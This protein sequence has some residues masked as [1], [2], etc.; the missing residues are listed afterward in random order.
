M[1][2]FNTTFFEQSDKDI[3]DHVNDWSSVT[4]ICIMKDNTIQRFSGF[5]DE[6][7]DGEIFPHCDCMTS[8]DYNTDDIKYWGIIDNEIFD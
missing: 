7:Y 2:V 1:K 3:W 5:L 8:D 4:F 6:N